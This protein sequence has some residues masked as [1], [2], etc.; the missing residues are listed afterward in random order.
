MP[1]RV[2]SMGTLLFMMQTGLEYQM[3]TS[4]ELGP[5]NKERSTPGCTNGLDLAAK[6]FMQLKTRLEES[7]GEPAAWLGRVWVEKS[8][9]EESR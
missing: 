3:Y 5:E 4:V 6:S 9:E 8:S 1:S 7:P 2:L